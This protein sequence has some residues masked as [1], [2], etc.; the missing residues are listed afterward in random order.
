MPETAW[1]GC[2]LYWCAW[3]VHEDTMIAYR[4]EDT[5]IIG[6]WLHPA[7][8]QGCMTSARIILPCSWVS[9][10]NLVPAAPGYL[11]SRLTFR[12]WLGAVGRDWGLVEQGAREGTMSCSGDGASP[13]PRPVLTRGM[14][15]LRGHP[16]PALRVRHGGTCRDRRDCVKAAAAVSAHLPEAP[17]LLAPLCLC[18]CEMAAGDIASVCP[19][20]LCFAAGRA[21]LPCLPALYAAIPSAC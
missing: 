7:G 1:L 6:P 19:C 4:P 14:D 5:R 12:C 8:L 13:V 15:S 2:S 18:V 9:F 16:A 3:A 10:G 21:A 17:S 20:R 11:S